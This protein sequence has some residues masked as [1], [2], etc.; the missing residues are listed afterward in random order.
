MADWR[1]QHPVRLPNL[2]FGIKK[3]L[4]SNIGIILTYCQRH[5]CPF[6][7]PVKICALTWFRRHSRWKEINFRCCW[8]VLRSR[9]ASLTHLERAWT[10]EELCGSM[11]LIYF[12]WNKLRVITVVKYKSETCET[13]RNKLATEFDKIKCI[14]E[15]NSNF[16][17]S[18]WQLSRPGPLLI[19]NTEIK[20]IN[21]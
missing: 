1:C 5:A 8:S 3:C 14:F 11:F 4:L 7:S 15:W 13:I 2:F 9:K 16:I 20:T 6:N 18:Q 12:Y 19:F 21:N 17:A 10:V